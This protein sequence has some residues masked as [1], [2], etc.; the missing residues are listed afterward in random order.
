MGLRWEE[1]CSD[2]AHGR[3]LVG[4][5][6]APQVPTPVH[7]IGSPGPSLQSLH[8]LKVGPH[9]GCAPFHP[10]ICLPPAV[11]HGAQAWP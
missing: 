11:I 3:P 10:A 2:L 8:D 4:P 9:Q 6:K 7:G 5:E 1:V